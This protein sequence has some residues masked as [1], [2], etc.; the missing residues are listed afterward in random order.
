[1]EFHSPIPR[2]EHTS[3]T[4]VTNWPLIELLGNNTIMKQLITI[5]FSIFLFSSCSS[6]LVPDSGLYDKPSQ[7]NPGEVNVAAGYTY[8]QLTERETTVDNGFEFINKSNSD[9]FFAQGETAFSNRFSAKLK[10]GYIGSKGLTLTEIATMNSVDYENSTLNIA[11]SPSFE[12]VEDKLSLSAPIGLYSWTDKAVGPA[13]SE[14]RSNINYNIRP[15]LSFGHAVSESVTPYINVNG[16]YS[17][18][19]DEEL[20][21]LFTPAEIVPTP[22]WNQEKWAL[23]A[24]IGAEFSPFDDKNLSINPAFGGQIN[25]KDLPANSPQEKPASLHFGA[26]INYKFN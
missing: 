6:I 17:F 18:G 22:I 23:A 16:N 12:I 5:L 1:M 13:D 19:A 24:N 25:L 20:S 3:K 26:L 10:V 11:L 15:T 9:R 7:L 21:N 14:E 4:V 8:Q 2:F